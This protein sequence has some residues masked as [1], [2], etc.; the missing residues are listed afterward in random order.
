[1]VD[2]KLDIASGQNKR[3]GFT[4]IDIMPGSDIVH[5]LEIF[6]WP[7][8]SDSVEEAHC[9][10]FIEHTKDLFK[11]FDE[12][13]R[14]MK[15]G[16][17]CQV[18]AP[19]YNSIRAWQDPTHTRAISENTFLYANK[20]WRETNKLNHYPIRCDFD[21][22]YGYQISAAWQSRHHEALQF[23]IRHYTNVV[24]DIYV[25]LMKRG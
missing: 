14:I 12:L 9:A 22:T 25:T 5:D 3:E 20:N 17:K 16:A 6:P 1:M 18:I 2:M 10:H 13:Y 8:E 7:I 24:D 11:F 21:F 4:G 15:V 23:A 19:Y